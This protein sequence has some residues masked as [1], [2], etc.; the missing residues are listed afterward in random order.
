M[1]RDAW[2]LALAACLG[3]TPARGLD[4]LDYRSF[5][6]TVH[7]DDTLAAK[8]LARVGDLVY[9]V[10]HREG[11]A[12][13]DVGDAD[14]PATLSRLDAAD[15]PC[16]VTVAGTTAYV[17]DQYRGVVVIDAGDPR[18]PVPGALVDVDAFAMDVLAADGILYVAD[19]ASGLRIFSL[20]DPLHPALLAVHDTAG[21]AL[22]LAKDGDRLFVA[23]QESGLYVF[24]VHDPAHPAVLGYRPLPHTANSVV[25]GGGFAY[26]GCDIESLTVVDVGNPADP[27]VVATLPLGAYG[28]GARIEGTDLYLCLGQGLARIDV[29]DP[30]QPVLTGMNRP[31]DVAWDVEVLNGQRALVANGYNLMVTDITDMTPPPV[32]PTVTLSTIPTGVDADAGYAYL[33][34]DGQGLQIFA[35]DDLTDITFVGGVATAD[36]TLDVAVAGDLAVVA[37]DENGLVTIDVSDRTAP[38]I[39][40]HLPLPSSTERVTFADERAYV[41]RWTTR[42]T[43][44][45]VSDPAAPSI[46]NEPDLGAAMIDVAVSGTYAFVAAGY[47]LQVWDIADGTQPV[48]VGSLPG[49]WGRAVCCAG[50][51]VFHVHAAPDYRG[52]LDVVD[53]SDPSAPVVVGSVE[54]PFWAN[55]AHY[56]DGVVYVLGSDRGVTIVDVHDPSSPEVL[57]H[58]IIPVYT[59]DAVVARDALLVL[60]VP[61]MVLVPLPCPAAVAVEP[62]TFT[63]TAAL[64]PNVP[65][66]FNPATTLRFTLARPQH[67]A[68]RI[69]DLTGR[70]VTTLADGRFAAGEHALCW[71]GCDHRG[72]PVASG[73]YRTVLDC[74]EGRQTRPLVL[75]R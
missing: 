2:W 33:A 67:A 20:A 63:S 51:Y 41:G 34:T 59:Y 17:A 73:V 28:L 31:P 39:V 35:I 58:W 19:F 6:R 15:W 50:S 45:D 13:V 68:L 4:C 62:P 8:D 55:R 37:D 24:D 66:P 43:I 61:G 57:Y 56:H 11:L 7:V 9:V 1:R 10:L 49:G 60:G 54:V 18:A 5:D 65:N 3:T 22:A 44:V 12:I 70:L 48:R 26:L 29:N 14:H 64:L 42:L 40:G 36:T 21:G 69:V 38:A 30:A 71:T 75:V 52:V 32:P 25:A 72:Q 23:G 74:D 46:L 53:V 47:S 16:A 27:A